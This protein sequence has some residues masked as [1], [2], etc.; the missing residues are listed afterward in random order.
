MFT[1]SGAPVLLPGAP[2]LVSVL[3]YG[4][5]IWAVSGVR[6]APAL[7][8]AEPGVTVVPGEGGSQ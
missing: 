8:A 7:V 3:A 2:F 5:A 4:L 1:D 6:P